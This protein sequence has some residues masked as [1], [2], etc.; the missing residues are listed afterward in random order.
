MKRNLQILTSLILLS[1]FTN[2]CQF[3]GNTFEYKKTTENFMNTLLKGE[4]DKSVEFM[5]MDHELSKNVNVDTMKLGLKNFRQTF[6]TN[7]GTNVDYTLM[8]SEKKFSTNPNENTPPN[9]TKIL[10]Q[11]ANEK[12]FGVLDVLFDDKSKKILN[13]T[14][15]DVK[16]PIP[17]MFLFWVIGIIAL[18]IPIFNIYMIIQ[19][20]KSNLK[21]KWLKYIAILLLN[22]PTLI[23][24][25]VEGFSFKL[26][27]FN[28]LGF[29][30]SYMGYLFSAITMSVPIAGIYWYWKLNEMK[31]QKVKIT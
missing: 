13:L 4:V 17:S 22:V 26:L 30:F 10:V 25:A 6:I 21:R 15:L 24:S 14:P 5:A 19:I 3:I 31:K 29:G 27:N 11:F 9:T 2:S 28:L 1:F 8:K 23:Y 7:F 20:K 18:L 16:K 12:E